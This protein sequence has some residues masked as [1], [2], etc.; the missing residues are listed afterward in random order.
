MPPQSSDKKNK[1]TE[2]EGRLLLAIKAIKNGRY[3]S[4]AAAARSFAIPISTLKARI[5]G[6]ESATEKRPTGHIFSQ[7]EEQSIGNWLLNMGSRGA[8]LTL[9]M[10]RDMANFLPSAQKKTPRRPLFSG[11]DT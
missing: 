10:L 11:S 8:T 2:Q 9:P 1:L 5:K 7:I 6:R 3:P 4:A